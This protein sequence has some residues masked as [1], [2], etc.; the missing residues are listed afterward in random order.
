M[1]VRTAIGHGEYQE[2]AFP[3]PK[4]G[5]EIRYGMTI[6]QKEIAIEYSKIV[7]AEWLDG[8]TDCPH[9]FTH[10]GETLISN[11][12]PSHITAFI[13]TLLLPEDVD[14]F[15]KDRQ[16]R[17]YMAQ[18]VWPAL[19]RSRVHLEKKNWI[20]FETE[21]KQ[22]NP[23]FERSNPLANRY[24]FFNLV[25]RF[26]NVFRPFQ[27]SQRNFFVDRI[28]AAENANSHKC[29]ELRDDMH[30]LGWTKDIEK[31]YWSLKNEWIEMFFILQ[32]IYLSLYWDGQKNSLDDYHLSQKRFSE[33]RIYYSSLFETLARIS[34]LA[35][36]IEGILA[37]GRLELQAKKRTIPLDEYRKSD[38]GT[39]LQQIA[40]LPIGSAFSELGNNRLRN[41]I[42]HHSAHYEVSSDKILYRNDSKSGTT[43]EEISYTRFCEKLLNLYMQ[44]DTAA[45]YIQWLCAF[46]LSVVR[47]SVS[48]SSQP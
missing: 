30:S 48:S 12:L 20:A 42:S 43:R 39:K 17:I 45:I 44:F 40:S 9:V 24:E 8:L 2:F 5:I 28:E 27:V 10:D 29:L 16:A 23:K 13:A 35:A 6:D 11:N 46:D 25:D 19:Q 38:N 22:C 31:E 26:G 3:C 15:H 32:P 36:G 1:T 14:R 21:M 33:L 37:T 34:V 7:N 47:H 4:C 18:K 41:G